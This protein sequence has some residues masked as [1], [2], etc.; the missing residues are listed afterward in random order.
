[1]LNFTLTKKIE[2]FILK[3]PR[4][5]QEI[6]EFLGKNWRTADRYVSQIIEEKGT[7]T[8]KTF[9]GG[10]RGALKI[11]YASTLDKVSN[12]FFQEKLEQEILR[13][14]KKEDF[15]AFDIFQYVK[16]KNKKAILEKEIS[17]DTTNLKELVD[18][19]RK[20]KKELISLSG[21]LSYLNLKKGEIDIFAEIEELI[22]RGVKMK[23]L[24]VVDIVG[25]DNITK[26]LS[27]NHKYGK[28]LIEIRHHEIPV[29]AFI[30]DREILRIKEIK[31]P[32]G[33]INELDK[34]LYI[35]YTIKDKEW[36]NWVYKIF[37]KI[38]TNSISAQKRLEEIDKIFLKK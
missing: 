32:T 1:M 25:K 8:T 31:E 24:C 26:L 9:R 35:F 22:K 11:V 10:T 19:L 4:S 27:L 15:S 6:A 21:N 30:F 36:A 20:T 37:Q 13:A 16:D 38:F 18:I 34:K 7:L 2:E 5:I 29:R 28:E 33:R 23:V 14:R 3:E 17:E 12:T